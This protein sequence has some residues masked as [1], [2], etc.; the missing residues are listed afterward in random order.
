MSIRWTLAAVCLSALPMAAFAQSREPIAGAWEMVSQ[1]NLDTGAVT[2]A[3]SGGPSAGT[4]LRV[5]YAEG[6]YVQFAAAKGRAKL[7]VPTAEMTREQL[8]ER[9]RMQGQY[10]TYKVTGNK[11][12]RNVISAADPNNEGR[13]VSDEFKVQGDVLTVIGMGGGPNRNN[14]MESTYRRLKPAS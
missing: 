2:Q 8:V 12:V 11:L 13:E 9:T 10:G 6:Y 14:K 4:P 5:I 1:K 7:S 3:G